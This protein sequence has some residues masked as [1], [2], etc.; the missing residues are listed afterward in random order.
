VRVIEIRK[1]VLGDEHPDTLTSM[2]NLATTYRDQGRWKAAEE[3]RVQA[4]IGMIKILGMEHPHTHSTITIQEQIR[5]NRERLA[6]DK[7]SS[8]LQ[9]VA[10][11]TGVDKVVPPISIHSTGAGGQGG[12][13]KLRK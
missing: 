1:R 4:A 12:M 9:E 3:L 2:G 7:D 8:D 13:Q 10:P 11:R 5:C 6:V